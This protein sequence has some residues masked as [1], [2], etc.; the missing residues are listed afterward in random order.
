MRQSMINTI[1]FNS[2]D[3][4]GQW[5]TIQREP[6]WLESSRVSRPISVSSIDIFRRQAMTN[7]EELSHALFDVRKAYRLLYLFQRRILDLAEQLSGKLGQQFYYWLP[8][9]DEEAVRGSANPFERNAWKMLPLFDA[10]FLYLLPGVNATD[11]PRK[12]QWLLELLLSPDDGQPEGGRGEANPAEFADP[13]QCHSKIYLYAF[14][15]QEDVQGK[16]W[17]RGVYQNSEW[18]EE[19]GVVKANGA[20]VCVIGLSSDLASLADSSAVDSLADRFRELV[21]TQGGNVA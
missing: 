12:G 18:P 8:A 13:A 16:D 20:G 4:V 1:S 17:W 3:V 5:H 11:A 19:D 6:D 2:L 15:V 10:S 7:Y 21:K 9:G 14:I